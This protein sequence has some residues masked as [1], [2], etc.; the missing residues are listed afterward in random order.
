MFRNAAGSLERELFQQFFHYGM[1]AAGADVFG[2]VVDD[3]RQPGDF[4]DPVCGKLQLDSVGAQQGRVLLEQRQGTAG[5]IRL[6]W[7]LTS[8]PKEVMGANQAGDCTTDRHF[9]IEKRRSWRRPLGL[10]SRI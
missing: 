3:A 4:F 7:E 10:I 5:S 6:E 9:V 8:F 1:E 2:L